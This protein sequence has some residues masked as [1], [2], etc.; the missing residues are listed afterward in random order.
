LIF[1]WDEEKNKINK[2]RHGVS[3][4]D[5]E[6]V[7][8]DENAVLLFDEQHSASEERFTIIGLD[9]H[10]RELTVC[11]CYRENRNVIRIIS[12]RKATKNETDLY[13]RN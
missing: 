12:A 6:T 10:Y 8:D 2:I 11:H 4:Q 13:W 1:E 7:F 3:F 9:L 5:A